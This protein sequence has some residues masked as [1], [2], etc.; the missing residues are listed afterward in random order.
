MSTLPLNHPIEPSLP[1]RRQ[2]VG[3]LHH[4][5]PVQIGR[6][7]THELGIA[8]VSV[9][10]MSYRLPAS[11]WTT[12]RKPSVRT[13]RPALTLSG[14]N[15]PRSAPPPPAEENIHR[16]K[17]RHARELDRG[18]VDHPSASY[19]PPFLKNLMGGGVAQE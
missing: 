19:R 13:L 3:E 6:H 11:P 2:Q 8:G 16:I 15:A 17:G 14:R 10:S 7:P 18:R 1:V 12:T 5:R 9:A 4:T